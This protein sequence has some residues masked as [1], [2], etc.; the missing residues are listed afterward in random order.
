MITVLSDDERRKAVVRE[1]R[2]T[3]TVTVGWAGFYAAQVGL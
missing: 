2:G 3:C 1:S